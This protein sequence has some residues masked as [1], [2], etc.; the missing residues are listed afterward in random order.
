MQT[1][2]KSNS[3]PDQTIN[4]DKFKKTFFPHLYQMDE[5]NESDEERKARSNQKELKQNQE[6]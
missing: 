2:K 1:E 5:E 4:F 3:I 6:K